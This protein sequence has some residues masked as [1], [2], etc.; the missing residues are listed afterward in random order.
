M[1]KKSQSRDRIE[2]DGQVSENCHNFFTVIVN[3]NVT[4]CTLGGRL[5]KNRIY[6]TKGDRVRVELSA[7]DTTKGRIVAR[8]L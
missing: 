8:L 3:G 7:F 1:T 6:V 2:F 4:Q 5:V